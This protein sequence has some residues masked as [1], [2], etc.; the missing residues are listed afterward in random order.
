MVVKIAISK[1]FKFKDLAFNKV[2]TTVFADQNMLL[3]SN[4]KNNHFKIA[5]EIEDDLNDWETTNNNLVNAH[6]KMV[7]TAEYEIIDLVGEDVDLYDT[8]VQLV[9]HTINYC[10]FSAYPN[11]DWDEQAEKQI[12]LNQLKQHPEKLDY[13]YN[14]EIKLKPLK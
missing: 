13:L 9:D 1:D 6:L 3:I 7:V 5:F 8:K 2:K 10:H 4:I 12:L 11:K 14:L